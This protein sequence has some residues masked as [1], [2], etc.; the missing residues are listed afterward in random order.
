MKTMRIICLLV[1]LYS[2]N[3]FAQLEID[4][5]LENESLNELGTIL[6]IASDSS[7][8]ISGEF[9]SQVFIGSGEI[10]VQPQGEYQVRIVPQENGDTTRLWVEHGSGGHAEEEESTEL[11]DFTRIYPV[12][13]IDKITIELEEREDTAISLIKTLL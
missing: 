9:Y 1:I 10:L 4:Y 5:S 6:F 2:L 7:I 3:G 8:T 11:T 13:F 12:P